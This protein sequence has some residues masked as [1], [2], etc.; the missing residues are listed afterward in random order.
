[1]RKNASLIGICVLI[2]ACSGFTRAPPADRGGDLAPDAAVDAAVDSAPDAPTEA[3]MP[4]LPSRP[5]DPVCKE[6]WIKETKTS[7]ACISRRVYEIDKGLSDIEKVDIALTSDG[8][9]LIAYDK[10]LF[11]DE[12]ELHLASFRVAEDPPKPSNIVVPMQDRY[13]RPGWGTLAPGA[14]GRAHLVYYVDTDFVDELRYRPVFAGGALGTEELVVSGLDKRRLELDALDDGSG[15]LAVVYYDH[16]RLRLYSRLRSKSGAWSREEQLSR[17]YHDLGASVRAHLQLTLHRLGSP[18]PAVIF[19]YLGAG[20]TKPRIT[21]LSANGLWESPTSLDNRTSS[22]EHAGHSAS[23]TMLSNGDGHALYYASDGNKHL[24]L[25]MASFSGDPLNA[26]ISIIEPAIPFNLHARVFVAAD[27]W[28]GL[29]F[30]ALKPGVGDIDVVYGRQV[31]K[32]PDLVW[33]KETLTDPI[34]S[35]QQPLIAMAMAPN[36]KPHIVYFDASNGKLFY[37]TR[38]DR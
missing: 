15:N 22:L 37:A 2:A 33:E 14:A 28:N 21:S 32:G 20:F 26:S 19:N 3:S 4:D 8:R 16:L 35:T 18:R 10:A 6:L 12:S 30:A 13:S 34:V 9:V 11:A 31:A 23:L 17:S 29:H 5:D 38:T 1:M 36:G 25:R 7:T 27:Q 24:A